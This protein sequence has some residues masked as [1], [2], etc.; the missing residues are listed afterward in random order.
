MRGARQGFQPFD[1][2]FGIIKAGVFGF[3]ITSIAC[4]KG[5][6]AEGGAEGIGRSTTQAVVAG[7]VFMLLAD[8]VLATILL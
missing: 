3:L 4:Y 6:Y 2:F 1:P 5:Y 8:P 7:C